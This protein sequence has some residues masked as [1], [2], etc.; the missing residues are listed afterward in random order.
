MS[1]VLLEEIKSRGRTPAHI[2]VIMDGNG[3]WAKQRGQLRIFG[4]RE[5]MKSVREIIESCGDV[6]VEILTLYAFSSEN[7]NRPKLEV[8]A[9]MTLLKH[10]TLSERE[11]LKSQG[12]RVRAIGRIDDLENSARDAIRSI[13]D[14]TAGG[15][16]MLL[17]LAINYGGRQEIVDAVR[18][19][20]GDVARGDLSPEE[21][22]ENLIAGCLYT[23]Q[24]PDPDLLIRTSGEMRI[25]NFLLYQLAYTEIYVTDT[26]WP[27]FRREN[28]YSAIL[29]YQKRERRFGKVS[30]SR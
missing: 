8:A 10:Y 3:R 13:E 19:L 30:S 18:T 1:D 16:R 22:D 11:E 27:D 12:V 28:L 6:G 29:D 5:G 24:D 20:A 9:L 23:S 21:I 7:W 17:N 15:D 25:S 4:H 2:A 14:Y 26:L